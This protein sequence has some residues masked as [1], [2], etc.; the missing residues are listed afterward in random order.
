MVARSLDA[1]RRVQD[2]V[3]FF[4]WVGCKHLK[5]KHPHLPILNSTERA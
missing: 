4:V 5:D 2:Q 3:H 1:W